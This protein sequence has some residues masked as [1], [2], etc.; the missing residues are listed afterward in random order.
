MDRKTDNVIDYLK[1]NIEKNRNVIIFG[2]RNQ[3]FNVHA[4][5]QTYIPPDSSTFKVAQN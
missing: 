3:I 1:K 5:S 2:G 4:D